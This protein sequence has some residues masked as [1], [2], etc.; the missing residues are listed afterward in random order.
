MRWMEFFGTRGHFLNEIMAGGFLILGPDT[1]YP[2]HHHTAEELYVPLTG[3]T[4]WSKGE[5]PFVARVAGEVIHHPSNVS[6]AMRTGVEPLV[7]LYLWRGGPLAQKATIT[8]TAGRTCS[9][10]RPSANTC[11]TTRHCLR[12]RRR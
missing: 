2:D 1:T 12:D 4:E 8:R 5:G 3:G 9:D 6:H 11:R 7:A 10:R